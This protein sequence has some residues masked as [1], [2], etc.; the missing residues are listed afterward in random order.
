M[1]ISITNPQGRPE[2]YWFKKGRT[3]PITD[4]FKNNHQSA[5][6]NWQNTFYSDDL[7]DHA[8]AQKIC[9]TCPNYHPCALW[10]VY[11]SDCDTDFGIVAG[12]DPDWRRRIREGR[13][14]FWDWTRRFSY[15]K[16]A[17]KA[18]YRKGTGKRARRQAEI[19]LCPGCGSNH[20]ARR[21]GRDRD[22]NRQKYVCTACGSTFLG[23][24]L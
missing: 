6:I 18:K 7:S 11:S 14:N 5:C 13:E 4:Q 8:I 1:T 20:D 21:D 9:A 16:K 3:K 2:P 24:E 17:A 12:M 23:E 15:S 22:E 10:A 19:P